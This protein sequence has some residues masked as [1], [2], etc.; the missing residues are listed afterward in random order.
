[1]GDHRQA[2]S[3]PGT[4]ELD[5]AT[6]VDGGATTVERPSGAVPQPDVLDEL[7]AELIGGRWKVVS[8]L[9]A[10]GFAQVYRARDR[11]S[12]VLVALK[13][14]RSELADDPSIRERFRRE[15]DHLVALAHPNVAQIY[16]A[17][18][19]ADHR[20]FVAMELLHGRTLS[21]HIRSR[22]RL[23]V[24]EVLAI[25]GPLCDALALAHA[26]GIVHRDITSSNV[27]LA[28]GRE[29]GR[30][31]LL[32]FG[33]SKPLDAPGLTGSREIVGTPSAMAPE[34][35]APEIGK[36]PLIGPH[37]DVYLLGLLMFQM[38]SGQRAFPADTA[39]RAWELLSTRRPVLSS[40]V[41][42]DPAIERVVARAM[43]LAPAER[44]ANARE[45][46]V[47]LSA[48]ARMDAEH[49]TSAA[50]ALFV[51]IRIAR[52]I[53]ADPPDELL[54]RIDDLVAAVQEL[55]ERAQLTIPIQA[56]SSLLLVE[57]SGDVGRMHA[58]AAQIHDLVAAGP[59]EANLHVNLCLHLDTIQ[60]TP[61]GQ[62]DP[63]S[64]VLSPTIWAA[65][66]D[67]DG[68]VATPPFAERL[69]VAGE[70]LPGLPLVRIDRPSE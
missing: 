28:D 33:I 27:F 13:V 48:A 34:Q 23:S 17:G 66:T 21:Q 62:L 51:E 25:M 57:P 55:A 45:L 49:R 43:R 5:E 10:G 19:T 54:D 31:V 14:L 29:S 20:P 8:H 16:D 58:I 32:D 41:A 3:V 60:S 2:G 63:A 26:R 1:M 24:A 65:D 11:D 7:P 6:L 42:V 15:V 56:Q 39:A 70:P 46:W 61:A 40:H 37:T 4:A 35:L 30:V 44:F 9:G 59:S 50:A 53:A 69:D 47:A 38:L 18:L 12:H 67:V 64:P 36:Q 22:G 68:I 52:E